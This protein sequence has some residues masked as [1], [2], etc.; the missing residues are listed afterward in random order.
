MGNLG[1]LKTPGYRLIVIFTQYKQK[2]RH[3]LPPFGCIKIAVPIKC[4][5][6]IPEML[7]CFQLEI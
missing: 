1:E 7:G 4:G 2:I 5:V 3:A 6:S